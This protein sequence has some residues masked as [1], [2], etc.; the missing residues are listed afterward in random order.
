[1]TIAGYDALDVTYVGSG[2]QQFDGNRHSNTQNIFYALN[3]T[4]HRLFGV[5]LTKSKQKI[6]DTFNTTPRK[7]FRIHLTQHHTENCGGN[8][9]KI[10]QS[11]E[12]AFDKTYSQHLESIWH[13]ISYWSCI[14][15]KITRSIAVPC[16]TSTQ[17]T[18]SLVLCAR[19]CTCGFVWSVCMC[20]CDLPMRVCV[21]AWSV[22]Y[23]S[24]AYLCEHGCV[25]V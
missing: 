17:C 15:R 22:M 23:L 12:V 1:M 16:D 7:S 11:I 4:L 2:N 5:H 10:T 6:L 24:R 25:C 8:C 18:A 21:S 14:W 20:V 13:K 3:T 9:H 19:T